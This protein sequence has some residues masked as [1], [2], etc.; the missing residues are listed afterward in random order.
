MTPHGDQVPA[1][2]ARPGS[3]R[4]ARLAAY[5]AISASLAARDDREL[6]GMVAGLTAVATGIGGESGR[7]AVD[8]A[9]VFVKLVP[10]TEVE[11]RPENALSTANLFALPAFCHYGIG[12]PGSP[13]F[14]A[15]RELAAHTITNGW[16]LSGEHGRFPLLYH[17]RVLPGRAPALSGELADTE[18]AVA[19]WGEGLRA[20]AEALR[21]APACLALFL[22]CFPGNAHEWL[23]AQLRAGDGAASR[24]CAM[25]ERELDAST[26]FLRARG[27]IHFDAHFENILT[28]G[29][30]LYFADFGLALSSRFQLLA[31]EATFFERHRDYDGCYTRAS[32]VRWLVT[33]LHGLRGGD[34]DALIRGYARGER[35]TGAPAWA[36]ALLSRHAALAAVMDRFHAELTGVSWETPYPAAEIRRAAARPGGRGR[37]TRSRRGP[38]GPSR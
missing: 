2:A 37:G 5:R 30:R 23:T 34:R 17:W 26:A 10:L 11:S 22:E 1:A 15:W 7:L 24:A 9:E 19:C 28:D 25:V 6:L 27:F 29:E 20:R 18:R 4:A 36:T 38:R 12:S 31:D 16:V 13:G 21:R 3:S 35:P 33:A 14:G 8:G 32:L